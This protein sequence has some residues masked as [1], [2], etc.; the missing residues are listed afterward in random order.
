MFYLCSDW[1]LH[2]SNRFLY[3]RKIPSPQTTFYPLVKLFRE[4]WGVCNFLNSNANLILPLI[5]PDNFFLNN[6][7]NNKVMHS[8]MKFWLKFDKW[9]EPSK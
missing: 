6:E 5:L 9:N 8:L 1:I 4:H 3:R 7:K 2:N